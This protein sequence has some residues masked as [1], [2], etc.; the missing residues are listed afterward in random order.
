[1][2]VR[3]KPEPTTTTTIT[4]SETSPVWVCQCMSV[5]MYVCVC[6]P[7][8]NFVH[9]GILSFPRPF[10]AMCHVPWN[11]VLVDKANQSKTLSKW[12]PF[13]FFAIELRVLYIVQAHSHTISS[14]LHTHTYTRWSFWRLSCMQNVQRSQ[15]C[16]NKTRINLPNN[17]WE[18]GQKALSAIEAQFN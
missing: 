10:C 2:R 1:M 17:A 7:F 11:I 5:C 13:N 16:G 15:V 6:V 14:W 4:S 18:S 9:N 8:S 3:Q 12:P